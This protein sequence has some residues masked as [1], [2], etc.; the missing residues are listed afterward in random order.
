MQAGR[1]KHIRKGENPFY[2]LLPWFYSGYSSFYPPYLCQAKVFPPPTM[3]SD[4][5]IMRIK[6][7]KME[8]N[9]NLEKGV[10]TKY[11]QILGSALRFQDESPVV[12]VCKLQIDLTLHLVD[13]LN[14]FLYCTSFW[15]RLNEVFCPLLL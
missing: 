9:K 13:A 15:M 11:W 8:K 7:I 1:H 10:C 3:N 6:V 5:R 4:S 12:E 2:T 14:G